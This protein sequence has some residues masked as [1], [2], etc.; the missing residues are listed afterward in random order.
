M[1][2]AECCLA[3]AHG[4][5]IPFARSHGILDNLPQIPCSVSQHKVLPRSRRAARL[6]VSAVSKEGLEKVQ[7]AISKFCSNPPCGCFS[8]KALVL[9]ALP[10]LW[11]KLYTSYFCTCFAW[12]EQ[13]AQVIKSSESS[14]DQ[15]TVHEMLETRFFVKDCLI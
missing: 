3:P 13:R 15:S 10:D 4:A 14:L 11:G 12:P 7:R 1:Q 8:L 5:P 2:V 9:H 6:R